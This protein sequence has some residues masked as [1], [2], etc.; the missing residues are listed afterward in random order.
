MNILD[1]GFRYTPAIATT[2]E[3]LRAKFR[4]IRLALEAKAKAEARAKKK[5]AARK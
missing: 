2:P 5:K 4:K 3:Y 1:S